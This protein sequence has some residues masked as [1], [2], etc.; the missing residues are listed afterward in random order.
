M[1]LPSRDVDGMGE[2]SQRVGSEIPLSAGLE[3][4]IRVEWS[5]SP[6]V[7]HDIAPDLEHPEPADD[8]FVDVAAGE[9]IQVVQVPAKGHAS[10]ARQLLGARLGLI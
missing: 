1:M 10:I 5:G 7:V 8:V 6:A 9:L 4:V 3:D 2:L